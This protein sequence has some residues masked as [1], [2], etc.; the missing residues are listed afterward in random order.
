MR[1]LGVC[2]FAAAVLLSDVEIGI[3]GC[4]TGCPDNV[5]W[6]SPGGPIQYETSTTEVSRL[7]ADS[8]P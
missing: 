1:C 3:G 7:V 4:P 8:N 2:V 6:I 5:C